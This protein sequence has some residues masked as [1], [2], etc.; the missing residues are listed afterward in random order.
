MRGFAVAWI[1]FICVVALA[2]CSSSVSPG[3]MPAAQLQKSAGKHTT[4]AAPA[5]MHLLAGR[6]I[7]VE[8]RE[9]ALQTSRRHLKIGFDSK[10]TFSGALRVDKY[11]QVVAVQLNAAYVAIWAKPPSRIVISG[12]IV[13]TTRLGFTLQTD[14]NQHVT[15][16]LTSRTH[17]SS[18]LANP[19]AV[20][21]LGSPSRGLIA[22]DVS[23]QATPI[24]SPPPSDSPSPSP[25][26][27]AT[28]TPYSGLS[29]PVFQSSFTYGG[30]SYPYTM[31]GSNPMTA[32]AS[33]V[34]N[35]AIVPLRLVFDNNGATLDA[36]SAATSIA[37]SPLFTAQSYPGLA[38]GSTQYGDALM[39]SEFWSSISSP[40][41]YHVL[42][43]NPTVEPTYTLVVP[44][45]L[46]SPSPSNY[47]GYATTT[48][49]Q[50]EG[51][52]NFAWFVQSEEKQII[53]QLGIAPSTLTIFATVN[54]KVLE[55]DIVG[56]SYYCCFLGYHYDF[57]VST[58]GG[59]ETWTT[60]WASVA[61]PNISPL[62][63]EV[64]EWLN[65]P[66]YNN[67][68][69]RWVSPETGACGNDELEVGDPVTNYSVNVGGYVLQDEAFYSWFSRQNPSFGINGWYDLNG[70]LKS[71][72]A[73]C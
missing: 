10:T 63:H 7:G 62:S 39:R 71:P 42:F 65:D 66:F 28:P 18:P 45:P 44:T 29:V 57:P 48:G 34:I 17:V 27:T 61:P 53:D 1:S 6:V 38:V 25:A 67:Y 58:P 51:Y 20:T 50:V 4:I 59:T 47:G 35:V 24:P 41:S 43:A 40:A 31:V 8:T 68:V 11:A 55:P 26:P 32:P 21:G 12:T 16:I 64:S 70:I 56:G 9:F 52:M 69:P 15:V 14:S 23:T 37:Q 60:A 72:A 19:V 5:D 36:T 73:N 22:S 54:A 33:S 30:K 3:A 2:A 46:P 13:A 49:G